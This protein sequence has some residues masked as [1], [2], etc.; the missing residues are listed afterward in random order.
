MSTALAEPT[1]RL[2]AQHGFNRDQIELIKRTIAKGATD[3]E[4]KLFLAQCERTGL[5]PFDRQIYFIK[6][7]QWSARLNDYEEVGQTQTSI[8]GF[9]VVAERTGEMDGQDVAWCGSDGAWVDVWLP[10][11]PPAAARV[12]VYRKG[13]A[14]G[15]PAI[16]KYREYVQTK[17]D[18]A[19]TGMWAKM[20]ANQVAKCAEALALRKAFPKQLSGLYTRDEMGQAENAP[21]YVVEAPAPEKP[22]LPPVVRENPLALSGGDSA[23]QS[24]AA[25]RAA[26][27]DG[28]EV[29]PPAQGGLLRT[30]SPSEGPDMG[31]DL[32]EDAALIRQVERSTAGKVKAL[33]WLLG[34]EQPLPTYNDQLAELAAEVCQQREPV[35]VETKT[36]A[37]GRNYITAIHRLAKPAIDHSAP[38]T[39]DE[40]LPF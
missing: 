40:P 28:P 34:A 37:A 2:A 1:T 4:L 15:F 38:I 20:P 39:D 18:G 29:D 24:S 36:S 32:P 23:G 35:R 30:D 7:R 11:D 3:D 25:S 26:A 22:A 5:D 31:V 14:H 9:R 12:I 6:R 19:A 16:A 21:S 27:A 13:C 17:R 33:V 10:N 8:D